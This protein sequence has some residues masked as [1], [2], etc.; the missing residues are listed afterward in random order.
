MQQNKNRK[1]FY[2]Y[3]ARCRS[4]H[5]H[6]YGNLRGCLQPCHN[7]V[8]KTTDVPTIGYFQ[9]CI[10]CVTASQPVAQRSVHSPLYSCSCE[11]VIPLALPANKVRQVAPA[12]AQGDL[13]GSVSPPQFL[14]SW[15]PY[16]SG[17]TDLP[18]CPPSGL[19]LIPCFFQ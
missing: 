15:T 17:Q 4:L 5:S 9:L 7:Y 8:G 6:Y 13:V 16:T 11:F 14:R 3:N 19:S 10:G 2:L 1:L 18:I 12:L